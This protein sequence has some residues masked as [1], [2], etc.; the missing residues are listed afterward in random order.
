LTRQIRWKCLKIDSKTLCRS[1]KIGIYPNFPSN[2]FQPPY[3]EYWLAWTH[4]RGRIDL[5]DT[6][7]I[8]H[9]RKST[10]VQECL[11]FLGNFWP[12]L[13][14]IFVQWNNRL[15]SIFLWGS[16]LALHSKYTNGE[17]SFDPFVFQQTICNLRAKSRKALCKIEWFLCLYHLVTSDFIISAHFVEKALRWFFSWYYWRSMTSFQF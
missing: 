14:A 13:I 4:R 3:Y 9:C 12:N 7:R 16:F 17:K 15:A 6:F 8:L 5:R 11:L 10:C 1:F 2:K